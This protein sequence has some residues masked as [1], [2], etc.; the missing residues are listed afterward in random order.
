MRR[1]GLGLAEVLH[2]AVLLLCRGLLRS[3]GAYRA[4]RYAY[5][6]AYL[7]EDLLPTGRAGYHL[8]VRA[9]LAPRPHQG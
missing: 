9:R 3:E 4:L 1:T 8:H 6:G 2:L 5:F 7:L